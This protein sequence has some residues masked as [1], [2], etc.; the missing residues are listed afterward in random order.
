[1]ETINLNPLGLNHVSEIYQKL[2]R[3]YHFCIDD[4]RG[5]NN[6]V[7]GELVQNL[8]YYQTLFEMLGYQLSEGTHN[9]Y[10]FAPLKGGS[11]T[12]I[13]GREMTLFMAVLYDYLADNGKD[14][15]T[16]VF[17]SPVIINTLPHLKIKQYKEI[18]QRIGVDNEKKIQSIIRRFARYGFLDIEDGSIRFRQSIRRFT[19]IFKEC[20]NLEQDIL[21]RDGKDD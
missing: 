11:I 4:N 18:M 15:I 2:S 10:Y 7:Y 17:E 5:E 16:A 20:K 19:E 6:M 21:E 8:D 12:N 3:G 1:M 13:I 14:P 9:I